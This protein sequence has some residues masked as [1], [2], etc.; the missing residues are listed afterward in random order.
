MGSDMARSCRQES[1]SAS[2]LRTVKT[3]LWEH[4]STQLK[5]AERDEVKRTLGRTLIDA[6][7]GLFAEAE[8]LADILGT[9]QLST[10]A[11]LQRQKLCS[12][13]NRSMVNNESRSGIY[14]AVWIDCMDPIC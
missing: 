5:P 13:P 8:A 3:L 6:N 11:V 4:L 12:N 9:V 1:C 2:E 14:S 10:T 7:E